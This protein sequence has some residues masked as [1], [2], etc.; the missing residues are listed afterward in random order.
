MSAAYPDQQLVV[1]N[2]GDW[3]AGY[4][5]VAL[6]HIFDGWLHGLH[7]N[8]GVYS[9]DFQFPEDPAVRGSASGGSDIPEYLRG[10]VPESGNGG[11]YSGECDYDGVFFIEMMGHLLFIGRHF[12]KRRCRKIRWWQQEFAIFK[13]EATANPVTGHVYVNS[14]HSCV[15]RGFHGNLLDFL[16]CDYYNK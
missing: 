16:L 3:N 6:Y 1:N 11:V 7:G 14:N 4:I 2:G 15:C 8:R 12:W 13:C 9:S 5:S 10:D